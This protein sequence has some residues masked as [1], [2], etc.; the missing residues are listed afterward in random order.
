VT[1]LTGHCEWAIEA[2]GGWKAGSRAPG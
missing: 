1:I 2:S